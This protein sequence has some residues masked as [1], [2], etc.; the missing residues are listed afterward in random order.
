[1]LPKNEFFWLNA[2]HASRVRHGNGS[3]DFSRLWSSDATARNLARAILSLD[4][5]ADCAGAVRVAEL[6]KFPFVGLFRFLTRFRQTP[7]APVVHAP[8]GDFEELVSSPRS[9]ARN[10]C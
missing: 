3:S 6:G 7:V 10:S 1:M 5:C 9:A 8:G 2:A 4:G